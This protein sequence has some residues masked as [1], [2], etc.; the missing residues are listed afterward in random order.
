MHILLS[1]WFWTFV[2]ASHLLR[3]IR[4]GIAPS[5]VFG[6]LNLAAVYVL[7]GRGAAAL[8]ASLS[9]ALWL[10]FRRARPGGWR[11]ASLAAALALAGLYLFY[12]MVLDH[13]LPASRLFLMMS[14]IGFSYVFL[15]A[16]DLVATVNGGKVAILDPVSLA[17]YLAPFHMLPAGPITPYQQYAAMNGEPP[18]RPS[19]DGTLA[20]I[21][22]IATGFL[23]KLVIAQ[24]LRMFAFGA[25]GPLVSAS[26][27]DSALL[28]VYIF[29]DFAGYSRVARA[30]GARNRRGP[31]AY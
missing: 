15:R 16:W 25:T 14:A 29:F 7:A 23:Y 6:G 11:V 1:P 24:A 2:L 3:F 5:L 19:F 17:G 27:F 31:G 12:K 10:V 21:N 8:L 13:G 9:L 30:R 20:A 26:W 28:V 22:Q 18:A 4:I